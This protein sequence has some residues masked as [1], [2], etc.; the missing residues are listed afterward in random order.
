[1]RTSNKFP[2]SLLCCCMAVFFLLGICWSAG[3]RLQVTPSMPRGL[4]QLQEGE[5]LQVGD[6][7]SFCLPPGECATL[8]LDRG[9]LQKSNICPSGVRPLVKRV[10]G[11]PGDVVDAASLSIRP[12]DSLNRPLPTVLSS[13]VIPDG[14]ALVLSPHGDS[15]DSRYF[16]LVPLSSLKKVAPIF[17]YTGGFSMETQQRLAVAAAAVMDQITADI[18]LVVPLPDEVAEYMG[19]F[20][21]NAVTPE[22]FGMETLLAVEPGGKVYATE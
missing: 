20:E 7:V 3:L 21:E 9:Y 4:Y 13:G 2:R 16:G 11:L 5:A 18:D 14:F 10:A 17:I 8:A 6:M 22:D 15:F 19:A 1:M 12:A